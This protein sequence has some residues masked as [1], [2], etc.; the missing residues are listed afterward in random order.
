MLCELLEGTPFDADANAAAEYARSKEDMKT[1]LQERA[2][3]LN[4]LMWL[5][6]G[7]VF[8]EWA[9]SDAAKLESDLATIVATVGI[10]AAR[11]AYKDK[12]LVE[13]RSRIKNVEEKIQDAKNKLEDVR[14]E[15][16]VTAKACA[17]LDSGSVQLEKPIPDPNKEEKDWKN[18][19]VFG[20]LQ[21][22][23]VRIEV[24]V[25][26][27]SLPPAI[28]AELDDLVRQAKIASGFKITLRSMLVDMDYAERVRALVELLHES[29]SASGGKDVEIDGV[30]FD[31]R[32]GAYHCGQETSPFESICFYSPDEFSGA[33]NLR[34]IIHPC[35]VRN[36]TPKYVLEDNPNPPGVITSADLPDAPTQVPVSTKVHQMLGGKRQQCEDGVINIVA[37][38]NPLPMHDREV[39]NAICGSEVCVVPFWTDKNGVRHSGRATLTRISKAPFVPEANLANE[40]DRIQFIEPF[41]KMSAVW[42]IRLGW[43]AK[44]KVI[45]NP[46]A[47]IPV[48]REVVEAFSDPPP[49]PSETTDNPLGCGTPLSVQAGNSDEEEDIVWAEVAE[50]YVQVCG[51]VAEARSVLTEL[52]QAGLSPDELREAVEQV[53]SEPSKKEDGVKFISPT[54]REMAMTFVIDCGGYEQAKACLDVYAEETLPPGQ[55]V[56]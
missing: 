17:V 28:H 4:E 27:E 39:T 24:T 10:G 23:S 50:N 2:F 11:A 25:L 35:S 37:F 16:A 40:D 45:P 20:R 46:N 49:P 18:S 44:N 38:G 47:S 33:G 51:T 5:L 32:G 9:N 52:E 30:R 43:Y 36:V 3:A 13:A 1:A 42:H 41:R 31:W 26:H 54:K 48:P 53:W 14:Y 21:G 6:C 56:D 19:D 22:Q 55:I 34:D 7:A 12:F 8:P 15:I 29:H